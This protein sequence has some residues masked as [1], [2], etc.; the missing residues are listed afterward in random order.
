MFIFFN[1]LFYIFNNAKLF[2]LLMTMV[3][4]KYILIILRAENDL[5]LRQLVST[6]ER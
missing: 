4:P 2:G 5:S 1:I 6:N 3:K